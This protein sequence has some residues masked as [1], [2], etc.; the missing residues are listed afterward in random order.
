MGKCR[1]LSEPQFPELT[2][3]SPPLSLVYGNIHVHKVPEARGQLTRDKLL[4]LLLQNPM[5]T[6]S[7]P[8][9][10]LLAL[11]SQAWSN[12]EN[13]TNLSLLLPELSRKPRGRGESPLFCFPGMHSG[14]RNL[15]TTLPPQ[16]TGRVRLSPSSHKARGGAGGSRPPAEG[17][18]H[19]ENWAH[20]G[21]LEG[22]NT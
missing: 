6:P 12:S 11:N 15:I 22:G 19:D 10:H 2:M 8:P 7:D 13:Q 21:A 5:E 20:R 3:A 16:R 14:P 1:G 18:R 17:G 4:L 9:S